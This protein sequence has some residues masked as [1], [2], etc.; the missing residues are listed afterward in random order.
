VKGRNAQTLH[1]SVEGEKGK[2]GE[3]FNSRSS[4]R[5]EVRKGKLNA[6]QNKN[7]KRGGEGVYFV[8]RMF[9]R[10]RRPPINE[11]LCKWKGAS[12]G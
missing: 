3:N 5:G 10:L 9:W 12:T 1:S 7:V 2:R 6:G 11:R 8:R 4:G